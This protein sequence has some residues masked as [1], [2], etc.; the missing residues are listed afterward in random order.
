MPNEDSTVFPQ[1]GGGG[2]LVYHKRTG[3]A[4]DCGEPLR[5]FLGS[6]ITSD[7]QGS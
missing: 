2:V 6:G 5:V 1:S 3:L 4:C 7:P